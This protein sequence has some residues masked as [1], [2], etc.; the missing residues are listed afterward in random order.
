VR[1]EITHDH[2]HLRF[3]RKETIRAIRS[4]LRREKRRIEG[5]SVVY[6]N[7][8]RILGINR[9]HLNHNYVT[10][11]ITFEL[12]RHPRIETEVYINLDRAR[13]QAKAYGDTFSNETRRLLVHGLLHALGY[14]DRSKIEMTLMRQ[15]ENAVLQDLTSGKN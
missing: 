14:D 15:K 2:P 9:K 3:S 13:S 11:V 12:E 6:T 8:T 7:N 1:I 5:V 4:V 10:D